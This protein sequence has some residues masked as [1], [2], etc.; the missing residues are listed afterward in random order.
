MDTTLSGS[1]CYP[2]SLKGRFCDLYCLFC[3]D[4]FH[5]IVKSSSLKIYADDVALDATVSSYQDCLNLQ[6]DLAHVYNWSLT[7][8]LALSPTKCEALN[9]TNKRSPVSFT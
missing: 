6:N 1:L 5:S 7:W 8:Q 2:V 4:D 9:I 3:I